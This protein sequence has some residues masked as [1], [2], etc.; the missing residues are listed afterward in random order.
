[1]F[2]YF[3]PML[4]DEFNNLLR[5]GNIQVPPG[6]WLYARPGKPND[7]NQASFIDEIR[8]IT[9]SFEDTISIVIVEF[10]TCVP[11][12]PKRHSLYEFSFIDAVATYALTHHDRDVLNSR[13]SP[14]SKLSEELLID[15][16][17]VQLWKKE[18]SKVRSLQGAQ[19]LLT[20]YQG[21]NNLLSNHNPSAQDELLKALD[22]RRQY[23]DSPING[24]FYLDN[25]ICY[26]R[27]GTIPNNDA[28]FFYDTICILEYYLARKSSRNKAEHYH[29]Q[30][31]LFI[32]M[33]NDLIDTGGARKFDDYVDLPGALVSSLVFLKLSHEIREHNQSLNREWLRKLLNPIHDQASVA[34]GVW[35]CG[36]FWGFTQFAEEYYAIASLPETPEPRFPDNLPAPPAREPAAP[37]PDSTIGESVAANDAPTPDAPLVATTVEPVQETPQ[38]INVTAEPIPGSASVAPDPTA[39]A[40]EVS[41]QPEQPATEAPAVSPDE[42]A[43]TAGAAEPA[44]TAG[45]VDPVPVQ[46]NPAPAA[47][48][49]DP[50]ST[51]DLLGSEVPAPKPSGKGKSTGK[52]P[53]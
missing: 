41:T 19:S 32:P 37:V 8:E 39:S 17:L 49:A 5:L 24:G 26:S 34:R 45:A 4:V 9:P 31:F 44:V 10:S 47:L 51:S 12:K 48:P 36:G 27:S 42:T 43:N 46:P 30:N 11:S 28:G 14:L 7:V 2:H 6:R 3:L 35:W 50:G 33:V 21:N 25:L 22:L 53:K 23:L 40:P 16:K 15:E 13:L 38:V 18:L 52:K 29:K 1:M 20:I